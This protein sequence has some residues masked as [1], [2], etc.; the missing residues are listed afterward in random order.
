MLRRQPVAGGNRRAAL[1]S[2]AIALPIA[3]VVFFIAYNVLS[4]ATAST[5]SS[6]SAS[7]STPSAGSTA[8]VAVPVASLSPAHAQ[9]CLAFIAELGENGKLHGL[10]ERHVTAGPEQN[11]AFGDPPI[12]VQCGAAPAKV[13]ATDF[14]YPLTGVC[15]YESTIP[16]ATVWTTL[17]RVV[18]VA[19][20]IPDRYNPPGQWANIFSAPLVTAMPSVKTPYNC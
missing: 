8:P 20:T 15:W 19:V 14:V 17:D 13:A 16:G 7:A 6:P 4:G 2:A 9:M 10:D 11:A 12:T 5:A 1:L 3:V 18:P